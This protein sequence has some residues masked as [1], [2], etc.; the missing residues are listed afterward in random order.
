MARIVNH[1][2]TIICNGI[3]VTQLH[4]LTN[5]GCLKG[6]EELI[7]Q[8]TEYNILYGHYQVRIGEQSSKDICD[9]DSDGIFN[10]SNKVIIRYINALH[11]PHPVL[12]DDLKY[13]VIELNR[14]VTSIPHVCIYQYQMNFL[15]LE[16]QKKVE[17]II[18]LMWGI[19]HY[20]D[21]DTLEVKSYFFKKTFDYKNKIFAD[22]FEC[23]TPEDYLIVKEDIKRK[24]WE[25]IFKGTPLFRRVKDNQ[26]GVYGIGE[27]T[28][29][30][31][32]NKKN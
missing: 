16:E 10:C 31:N 27:D 2:K 28:C 20:D 7:K 30:R 8:Q 6:I 11:L 14:P 25:N 3:L 19:Y 5:F 29:E 32:F 23:K 12:D 13:R 17:N 24:P 15:S 21:I 4:F 18:S 9:S 22:S 1:N 26:F